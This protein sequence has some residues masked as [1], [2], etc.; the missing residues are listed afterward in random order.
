[1][2]KIGEN[3]RK[4]RN[5]L[6]LTQDQLAEMTGYRNRSSI[7]K[8]EQGENDPTQSKLLLLAAALQCSPGDLLQGAEVELLEDDPFIGLK[9]VLDQTWKKYKV[10][11]HD[12]PDDTKNRLIALSISAA[13]D[14]YRNTE[15]KDTL[16]A[17][18]ET[19]S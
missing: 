19:L 3:I 10:P 5:Q 14:Y 9:V 17:D 1:M 4:R 15:K 12:L 13:S 8:I 7:T 18:G 16:Q 11:F 6:G 2:K